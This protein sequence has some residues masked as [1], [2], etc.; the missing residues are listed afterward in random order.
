MMLV[1][2]IELQAHNKLFA[3]VENDVHSLRGGNSCYLRNEV[4]DL[5]ICFWV[6]A[7]CVFEHLE[8]NTDTLGELYVLI[9]F[10]SEVFEIVGFCS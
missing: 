1:F 6:E 9:Q 8:W 4:L 10:A 5:L 2:W 3:R 7:E